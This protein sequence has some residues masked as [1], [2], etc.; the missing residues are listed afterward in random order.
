MKP[1]ITAE[2]L[3]KYY[4]RHPQ[5]MRVR[6]QKFIHYLMNWFSNWGKSQRFMALN[7]ISLSIY[8]G[9][10]VGLIGSNGSGK[11]TLLRVLTGI[12][13]PTMGK[14]VVNGEFRELF[15]LNAGFNMDISGRKNIY[16][17][18]AM[19][20]I[21]LEEIDQK[22]DKIIQFSG[23]GNFIDD[24]V[25]T[26]STG[27]RSRLGFSLI[28]HTLPDIIF[29]DEALSAG[30]ES[31]RDKCKKSL[32]NFRRQKRTL[33]IVSHNLGLIRKLC[34]RIIWLEGGNLRMDGPAVEV[35][36]EYRKYQRTRGEV[37]SFS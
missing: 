11:S 29:I 5:L 4:P 21:S 13:E 15:A 34:T 33:V 31:F 12:S 6:G 7:D 23:L 2:H 37:T 35:I 16:L 28:I 36:R 30:D 24:P 25:K 3:T 1:V 26:Y 14:V 27:M 17:Y 22:I 19:K 9:E 18:A 20:D 10:A 32:L 8:P